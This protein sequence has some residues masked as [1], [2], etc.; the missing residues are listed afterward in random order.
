[1]FYR[2]IQTVMKKSSFALFLT[3][4]DKTKMTQV[5][6]RIPFR[7]GPEDIGKDVYVI[8]LKRN[9]IVT[10]WTATAVSVLSPGDR[11]A[12]AYSYD[13]LMYIRSSIR[14]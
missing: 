9:G 7:I 5:Q 2:S 1:M 8:S 13:D 3:I 11:R 14:H 4:K 6:H 12:R 10:S